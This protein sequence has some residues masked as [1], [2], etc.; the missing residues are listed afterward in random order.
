[1]DAYVYLRIAPGRVEDVVIELRG[2][3]GVRGAVATVGEWDAVVAVEGPD[4]QTIGSRILRQ[5]HSV[6]GVVR[7]VT[8]PV[9]SL[10]LLGIPGTGRGTNLPMTRE[11]DAC[12][13]HIRAD[14]GAVVGIVQALSELHDVS[15]VAVVAGRFDVVAEIPLPWEQAARIILEQ[16]HAIP[17]VRATST[18]VGVTRFTEAD[19]DRDQFSAWD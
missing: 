3:R 6:E 16:V 7:T 9:L 8:C 17:G 5:I 19:E 13:V 12:Y 1:M 10:D 11:G 14:G 15:G 2:R 4:L 18:L